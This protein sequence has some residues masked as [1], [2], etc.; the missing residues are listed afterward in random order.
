MAWRAEPGMNLVMNVHLRP[1]GKPETVSP[2]I[3]L[4]F[5]DKPQTQ[6][7]MLI[8]LEHDT[9][10]DIPAGDKDFVVRDEFRAPLDLKVLAVY[11][12]AHYLGKVL[13]AYAT[14]PDGSQ[15]WLI[16]IP[17]WD[18]NWQGVYRFRTPLELRKGTVIT[19]EYHYDNSADNVRNPNNPPQRVVEGDSAINEM[20]HLWLQ[21]LPDEPGDHRVVLQEALSRHRL[22]KYPQDFSAN[23]ILGDLMLSQD[24]AEEAIPYFEKASMA[25]KGSALAASELG[26]ALAEA[27]R[28]PEAVEQLQR[29]LALDPDYS[30]AR[31][32]LAGVEAQNGQWEAAAKDYKEVVKERPEN[33]KAQQH[34]GEVL[35]LWG[36]DLAKEG[37]SEGAVARY[38]DA[39]I[40]RA[41][42]PELHTSLGIVLAKLA[43][44]SEAQAEFQAALR[45]NP[46]SQEAREALAALQ[47]EKH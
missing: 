18:L 38:R 37:E 25:L 2:E 8:Q 21:V 13:Q 20:G 43:R 10:I 33:S 23:F 16:R 27:G 40:Y 7:P 11:P 30:D 39:L 32:N 47:S 5:T 36:D 4:Y 29:A 1:S 46:N 19:M 42:D 22:E 24:K 15:K 3:G 34:L 35:L 6:F 14:L 44:N 41:D 17:D 9:S 26:V 28:V 45:I 31:Y 12:H